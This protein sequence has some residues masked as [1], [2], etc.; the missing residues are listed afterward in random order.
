MTTTATSNKK[1]SSGRVFGRL[2][3]KKKHVPLSTQ[4]TCCST[5]DDENDNHSNQKLNSYRNSNSNNSNSAEKE[6][7]RKYNS[8]GNKKKNTVQLKPLR[9]LPLLEQQE[10]LEKDNNHAIG[11]ILSPPSNGNSIRHV[12]DVNDAGKNVAQT[13]SDTDF[14]DIEAFHTED[15][16]NPFQKRSWDNLVYGDGEQ[17]QNKDIPPKMSHHKKTKGK[18]KKDKRRKGNNKDSNEDNFQISETP[19]FT[20]K[21]PPTNAKNNI[22]GGGTSDTMVLTR[23]ALSR[24]FGRTSLPSHLAKIWC[25]EVSPYYDNSYKCWNYQILVQREEYTTSN[26]NNFL[27]P[28]RGGTVMVGSEISNNANGKGGQNNK[29]NGTSNNSSPTSPM[30]YSTEDVTM[31]NSFTAANVTRTLKD[32]VWLERALRDEY[33]GALIFPALSMTLTS[34]TDWTTAVTLDKE[35][36]ERGEWDP[37]TL[38]NEL[39]DVVLEE[40][41]FYDLDEAEDD[42][43]R[44]PFDPKLI[45]DWLNDILNGVRGKGELILN[46][47]TLRMVDVMHSESMERFFYGTN[48]PLVDLHFMKKEKRGSNWLPLSLDLQNLTFKDRSDN[49]DEEKCTMKGL[50]TFPLLCLNNLNTCNTIDDFGETDSII[51]RRDKNRSKQQS[52]NFWQNSILSDELKVQSYYIGLQR[53]N[54][55]RAMYRLRILLETEALLSAAW[56]RF[57]ISLSN[58]FTAGKDIE[59]CKVGD[60][61]GKK[62]SAKISK[63]KVDDCLR[64]LARQKVDRAT[65]SLKV[66]SSMLSAYYADFSAVNPS[67]SAFSDGLKQLEREKEAVAAS[68]D[69]NWKQ[70]LKAVSPLTLFQ[71]PDSIRDTRT[72]EMEVRVYEQRQNFNEGLMKASLLQLCNSIDIRVSRMS[73]KFFKMESGQASLLSNAAEQVRENLANEIQEENDSEENHDEEE[74]ELIRRMLD[75]RLKQNYKFYPRRKSCS[76]SHNG[77]EGDLISENGSSFMDES[78]NDNN[79]ACNGIVDGVL[80][81]AKER[82]GR[83]DSKLAVSILKVVGVEKPRICIENTTREVRTVQRLAESLRAQIDRCREAISMLTELDNGVS[84]LDQIYQC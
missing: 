55:L 7:N 47:S 37:F 9:N 33:H 40:E 46:Y 20:N 62:K 39:L 31:H 26:N 67:L 60:A 68:S 19:K 29:N 4:D 74:L 58:L 64:T 28:L 45:S 43:K 71:D 72:L 8:N 73:W 16:C 59:S 38:S 80:D 25:V 17:Q 2:F 77:S 63:E 81:H 76:S 32:I 82:L 66:L 70:A 18:D 53:E 12:N 49:M 27:S 61:K 83:W 3:K 84:N 5:T 1:G 41:G 24:P 35:T 42:E 13:L 6:N 11:N 34:G 75:L 50:I 69:E 48:E 65:P 79:S 56:K 23:S 15:G 30:D 51:S 57:A 36:F 44:P 78:V 52:P 22:T 21:S 10:Q 14:D 54:T